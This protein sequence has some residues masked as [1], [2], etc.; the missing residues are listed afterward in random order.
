MMPFTRSKV[1]PTTNFF[2]AFF[3]ILAYLIKCDLD[4][5]R[6]IGGGHWNTLCAFYVLECETIFYYITKWMI[7]MVPR[8]AK[9]DIPTCSLTRNAIHPSSDR[10]WRN[11][12]RHLVNPWD[13]GVKNKGLTMYHS[14]GPHELDVIIRRRRSRC[15]A[16]WTL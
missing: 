9:H 1:N 11:I 8:L 16:M 7:H 4:T 3:I 5:R 15:T 14:W 10:D 13:K 2:C 6:R 12:D